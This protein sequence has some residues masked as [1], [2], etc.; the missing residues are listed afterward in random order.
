MMRIEEMKVGTRF[1]VACREHDAKFSC[2]PQD[3]TLV[4]KRHYAYTCPICGQKHIVPAY[5]VEEVG[6]YRHS[7]DLKDPELPVNLAKAAA[8]QAA[9]ASGNIYKKIRKLEKLANN[10]RHIHNGWHG[11][12]PKKDDQHSKTPLLDAMEQLEGMEAAEMRDF[13]RCEEAHEKGME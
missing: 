4:N 9:K 8:K 2:D 3:L 7:V 6:C 5:R 10:A 1:M 11:D 12:L 13:A